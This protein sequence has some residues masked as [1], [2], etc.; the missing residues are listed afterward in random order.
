MYH[1]ITLKLGITVKL[2]TPDTVNA[3]PNKLL[4]IQFFE[5]KYTLKGNIAIDN[6]RKFNLVNLMWNSLL[7][8][9]KLRLNL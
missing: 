3:I 2:A 9:I 1:I 8:K 7:V 5:P 4:Q 6:D